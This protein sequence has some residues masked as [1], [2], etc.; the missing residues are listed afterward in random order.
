[1]RLADAD[2]AFFNTRTLFVK[3][4]FLLAVQFLDDQK[5]LVLLVTESLNI[6][7]LR[8]PCHMI[9]IAVKIA[10]LLLNTFLYFLRSWSA[11]FRQ[12]EVLP[13]CFFTI[14]PGFAALSCT[15]RMKGIND[16]F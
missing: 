5:I 4:N 6:C 16:A 7:F 12:R 10:K 11:L 1:M 14:S 8:K 9:N 3:H 2:N 13:P 15:K